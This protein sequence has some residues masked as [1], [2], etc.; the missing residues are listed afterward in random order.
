MSS[1]WTQADL[2]VVGDLQQSY[3]FVKYN[4]PDNRFII[5]ADDTIP[6]WLTCGTMLD[7]TTICGADKFGNVF[8]VRMPDHVAQVCSYSTLH[9]IVTSNWKKTLLLLLFLGNIEIS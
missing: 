3:F 1:L 5:V 4:R 7:T 6:R 9:L 8:V 2:I